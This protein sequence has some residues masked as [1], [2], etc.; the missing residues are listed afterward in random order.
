MRFWL[1]RGVDGFRL[2]AI[3]FCFHDA[4]LRDN[5]PK[6]AEKR[7][8]SPDNRTP[9]STTTTTTPSRRTCRSWS[10]ARAAG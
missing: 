8:F 3:N 1:D 4:Q 9:T 2:D 7:G 6:P 10:P 5:P